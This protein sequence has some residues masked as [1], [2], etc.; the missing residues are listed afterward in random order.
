MNIII[1]EEGEKEKL[2]KALKEF[3][4]SQNQR[5]KLMDYN[6]QIEKM[7]KSNMEEDTLENKSIFTFNMNRKTFIPTKKERRSN[8]I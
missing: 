6:K 4:K 1:N 7:M 2:E 8:K 5:E 3:E